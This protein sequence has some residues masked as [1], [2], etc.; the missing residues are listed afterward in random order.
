MRQQFLGHGQES[1]RVGQ[2]RVQFERGLINP[3][4]MNRKPQRLF[5]RLEY[6]QAQATSLSP[7]RLGY[8]KQLLAELGLLP[9]PGIE[10]NDKMHRQA[11][12]LENK[13]VSGIV[14]RPPSRSAITPRIEIHPSEVIG[15]AA[16]ARSTKKIRLLAA[17]EPV[18]VPLVTAYGKIS[19]HETRASAIL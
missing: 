19:I 16:E 2:S 5:Q 18:K 14:G 6:M 8:Q 17:A 3:L 9:R 10:P 13:Y 1:N 11:H 12:L 15:K 4:G 7:A